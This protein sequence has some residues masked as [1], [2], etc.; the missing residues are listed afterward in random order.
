M[1]LY[2]KAEAKGPVPDFGRG[3][4][5]KFLWGEFLP[6]RGETSPPGPLSMNGEGEQGTW[7]LVWRGGGGEAGM[8]FRS[9]VRSPYGMGVLDCGP[10][11]GGCWVLED[12]IF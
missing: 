10:G 2:T 1:F 12:G 8:L 5:V 6:R 9:R 7:W 11:A 4:G 3:G